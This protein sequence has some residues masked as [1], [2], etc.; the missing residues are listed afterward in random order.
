[1]NNIY[2]FTISMGMGIIG[3]FSILRSCLQNKKKEK[4][5]EREELKDEVIKGLQ[6]LK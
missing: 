2:L 6:K 3:S 1:M 4:A 5:R